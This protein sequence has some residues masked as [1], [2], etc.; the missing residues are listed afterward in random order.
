MY[1]NLCVLFFSISFYM[2]NN[3]ESS[4]VLNADNRE[5]ELLLEYLD[6]DKQSCQTIDGPE[7]GKPCIFPFKL[8]GEVHNRCIISEAPDMLSTLYWCST[9][10]DEDG[11]HEIGQWGACSCG[12]P[13][14]D[15]E[16]KIVDKCDTEEQGI[17]CSFP[18]SARGFEYHGCIKINGDKYRCIVKDEM[19]PK[20]SR[21]VNCTESCPRDNVLSQKK[22][23]PKEIAEKLKTKMDVFTAIEIDGNC[24][25]YMASYNM[26]KVRQ[27]TDNS[28]QTSVLGQGL[29]VDWRLTTMTRRVLTPEMVLFVKN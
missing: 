27:R 24:T 21:L 3:F 2:N 16:G 22:L 11:N 6:A 14:V 1:I 13:G 23:S 25:E 17:Q 4:K 10:V 5:E 15:F 12:C 7:V 19:A 18:F 20:G 26:T 8:Y 29:G 28:F 9:K